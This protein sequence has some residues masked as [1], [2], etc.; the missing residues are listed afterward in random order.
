[1]DDGQQDVHER[2]RCEQTVHEPED[3]T[4]PPAALADRT[5]DAV[6]P[7][8]EQHA[9]QEVE[10]VAERLRADAV[11]RQDGPEQEREIDPRQPQLAR[12]AQSGGENE[13]PRD[14]AGDRAPNHC[15]SARLTASAAPISARWVNACGKFPRNAF[16]S[17][18][19]S[20]AYRP[21]SLASGSSSPI[22]LVAS[23]TRRVAASACAS[24]NEQARNA[25]SSPASASSARY[26][27]TNGPSLSSRRT[28][29]TVWR[30]RFG[31]PN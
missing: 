7:E 12:R 22:R 27:Q 3:G 29:S 10:A 16:V 24:Q 2:R 6:V 9:E 13:R 23:S 20:S 5:E 26:R 4:L 19:I 17:R 30:S 15:S 1:M 21:T 28:A 25:P 31:S 8:R 14:S 11:L 18:S